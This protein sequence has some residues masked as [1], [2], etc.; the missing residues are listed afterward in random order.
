M[1]LNQIHAIRTPVPVRAQR[2]RCTVVMWPT[3]RCP[4]GLVVRVTIAIINLGDRAE[5]RPPGDHQ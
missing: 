5:M 2:A 4:R 1:T 3:H